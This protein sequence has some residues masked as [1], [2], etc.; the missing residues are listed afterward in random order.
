MKILLTGGRGF[1]GRY[2]HKNL[3]HEIVAPTSAQLN[4]LDADCVRYFLTHGKFDAVIHCAV[5]GRDRVR[6]IDPQ[7]AE[8][9][10][11][12]FYNLANNRELY[13]KLISFGSGAEYG[14]NRESLDAPQDDDFLSF[15]PQE[16]YGFS[17]N[18]IARA[19]R[20]IPNFYNLRVFACFDTSEPD[21][22]LLKR[23]IASVRASKFFGV[24]DRFVD[25]IT[26]HDLAII[27]EATL[28][29]TITDSDLNCVYR[30]K[31]T[32]SEILSKYCEFHNIDKGLIV[33]KNQIL[34]NNYI[35]HGDKLA[36]YN[37][38]L[39]GLDAGLKEYE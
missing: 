32:V 7:I 3:N 24:D 27:T 19:I 21:T 11:R 14:L 10:L 20:N 12:M 23:F 1:I 30:D 5:A 9:N 35:G 39:Q 13:G 2:L 37:L 18:I 16:S 33:V 8:D 22:Q 31:F 36:R 4:L 38:P 26:L 6:E 15:V 34:S 17:K 28:N 25:F 29:G